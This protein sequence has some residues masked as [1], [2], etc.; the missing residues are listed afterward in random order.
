MK[1]TVQ[2]YERKEKEI[3]H[4][5]IWRGDLAEFAN[6]PFFNDLVQIVQRIDYSKNITLQIG[7]D[8]ENEIQLAP[9]KYYIYCDGDGS[10]SW[11][12]IK[13][14]EEKYKIIQE[15]IENKI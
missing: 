10:F 8:D 5:A 7:D 4:A 9:Y 6:M 13:K 1:Q 2:Q 14:F 15:V 11:M 12:E 3:I